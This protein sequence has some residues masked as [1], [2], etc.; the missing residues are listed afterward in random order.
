MG[1]AWSPAATMDGGA[2]LV[3]EVDCRHIDRSIALETIAAEGLPEILRRDVTLD[4]VTTDQTSAHDAFNGCVPHGI[5]L[6]EAT[7][8]R[9]P[10]PQQYLERSIAS[11]A[12]HVEAMLA[13]HAC[14]AVTF[15]CGNTVREQPPR[16]GV[17]NAF[18]IPGI[19]PEYERSL[20]CGGK[21]RFAG[22]RSR[23]ILTTIA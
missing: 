7:V 15:D 4:V 22:P 13:F 20:P 2:A 19:V 3:V 23:E 18:D 6:A 1:G 21:V 16:A 12:R 5:S 11:M 8:S 14:G 17:E 10:H 9:E